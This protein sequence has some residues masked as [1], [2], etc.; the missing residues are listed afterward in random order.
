MFP[1]RRLT[2][3]QVL[4]EFSLDIQWNSC[5]IISLPWAYPRVRPYSYSP[6]LGAFHVSFFF[7]A[8]K[9]VPF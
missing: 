5:L 2:I 3:K 4:R 7:L 1:L 9:N 8:A 6:I